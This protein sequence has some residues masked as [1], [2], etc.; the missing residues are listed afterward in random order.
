[1]G[2]RSEMR[3]PSKGGGSS[4]CF[5]AGTLVR[6]TDGPRDIASLK[7]GDRVASYDWRHNAEVRQPVLKLSRKRNSIWVV[8]FADGHR[9]RTTASH[10]LR[11]NG[12]WKSAGSIKP[13]D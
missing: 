2:G 5:P 6:T 1:M 7:K 12:A 11:V 3:S 13:G 4:G 9:I 10:S 8:T